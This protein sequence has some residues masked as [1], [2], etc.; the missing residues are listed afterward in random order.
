MMEKL[1]LAA[2]THLTEALRTNMTG[3]K[4]VAQMLGRGRRQSAVHVAG[5][6]QRTDRRQP[7]ASW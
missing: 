3:G 7:A 2:P 6:P 4:T 5:H 1:N